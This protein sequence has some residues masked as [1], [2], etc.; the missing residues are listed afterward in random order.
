MSDSSQTTCHLTNSPERIEL[1]D[2]IR[3]FAL[4]GILLMNLEAFTGPILGAMTGI[5]SSLQGLNWWADAF[6]YIFVQGKFWTLFS[7]LFGIGFAVMFERA[8]QSGGNFVA[9]YRRRLW[10]LLGIGLIHLLLIWEGD[11]LFSYALSGFVLLWMLKSGKTYGLPA[12]IAMYCAPLVL[13]GIYGYTSDSLANPKELI[14]ELAEESQILGAGRYGDVLLWRVKGFSQDL[15]ST[16]FLLPMTVALFA[17][18]VRFYRNGL[19]KPLAYPDKHTLWLASSL[20]FSGL[21][22]MLLSV[23]IAPEIN[24]L[25]TDWLFVKVNVLNLL[26]GPLM[27]LG[28]FFGLCYLWSFPSVQKVLQQFAPLGKMALTNYLSQSIICTLIFYGYGLG[29]YQQL[30]RAWHVPF[31]FALVLLQLM[32]SQYWL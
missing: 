5:D 15:F 11:I 24:P 13:L 7:L 28:Y 14:Q 6:I 10:A 4:L 2:A 25:Q 30:P 21:S 12:L 17:L 27:C 23:W 18:G 19:V 16:L 29:Y 9:I 22:L 8:K 1:L 3:G 31:A 32:F 20:W 26:A